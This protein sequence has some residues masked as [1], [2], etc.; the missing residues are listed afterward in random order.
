MTKTTK[1]CIKI[2][3]NSMCLVWRYSV[4]ANPSG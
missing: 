2:Q 1:K 4:P 3:D